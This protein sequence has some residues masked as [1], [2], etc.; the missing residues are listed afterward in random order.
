MRAIPEKPKDDRGERKKRMNIEEA[1]NG[2]VVNQWEYE[3]DYGGK[4][5][6]L[7]KSEEVAEAVKKF[8]GE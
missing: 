1:A 6:I 5:K 3:H 7:R 8:L 2:F 4:P